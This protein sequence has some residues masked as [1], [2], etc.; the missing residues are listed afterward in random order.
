MCRHKPEST[1]LIFRGSIAVQLVDNF[2]GLDYIK[3]ENIMVLNVVKP[4]NPNQSNYGPVL[5]FNKHSLPKRRFCSYTVKP[6][7]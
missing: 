5:P 1:Y 6:T 4:L 2:T 3:Q 7:S